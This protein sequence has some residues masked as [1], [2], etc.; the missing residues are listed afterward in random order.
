MLRSNP[1]FQLRSFQEETVRFGL[2]NP[3]SIYALQQGLGKTPTAIV[4][5][6]RAGYRHTLIVCPSYLKLKWAS[7]IR[8]IYPEA[9]VM[10]LSSAKEYHRPWAVD[11]VIITYSFLDK[12]DVLFE[13]AECVIIDE[14]QHFKETGTK[15]TQHLHRLVFEN[16]PKSCLIL[17]GTPLVNRV[18]EFYSLLAICHYNPKLTNSDFLDRFQTYVDFAQTFSYLHEYTIKV[19]TKRGHLVDHQVKKWSGFKNGALLKKYT[20]YCLI[21]FETDKVTDLPAITF[22]DVPVSYEE[23]SDLLEEFNRLNDSDDPNST[24]KREA[25]T[26]TAQFTVEYATGL[27]DQGLPVVIFTDHVDTCELI[28]KKL[29][30]TPIHGGVSVAVRQRL[31]EEFQ[32]GKIDIIVAT[33]GSFSTGVD[34]YRSSDMILN[35]PPWVPGVLQQ[36][37][38]RIRRIGQKGQFCRIH[39]IIGSGASETIYSVLEDKNKTINNVFSEVAR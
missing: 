31:G 5:A 1:N 30:A 8:K 34:L 16:S 37:I 22:V 38:Y 39:R 9:E 12:A 19:K 29:K 15:R 18:Y 21:R 6:V 36:A 27:L 7:E 20:D 2:S 26:A 4:T 14:G 28:A 23:N 35:D 10:I 33:Y 24:I 11:F 3:Y 25:A 13:W 32:N 17:T